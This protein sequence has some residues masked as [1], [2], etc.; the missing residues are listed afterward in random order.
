MTSWTTTWQAPLSMEFSRQETWSGLPFSSLANPGIKPG[1]P[2]WQADSLLT[3]PPGK[4]YIYIYIKEL[5]FEALFIYIFM[6]W[7]CC[8]AY[9]TLLPWPGTWPG[10]PA[11]ET[12]RPNHLSTGI[13]PTIFLDI[14]SGFNGQLKLNMS[15]QFWSSLS[16]FQACSSPCLPHLR[17]G[18]F[19]LPTAGCHL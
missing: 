7:P 16:P 17:K 2:T 19:F 4:Q 6:F 9:R 14:T 15:K 8:I 11:V 18:Q 5:G 13:P 3:E 10:T 12:Q 1:S